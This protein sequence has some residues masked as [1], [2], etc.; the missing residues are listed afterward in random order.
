MAGSS[1]RAASMAVLACMLS[2][3]ATAQDA[4]ARQPTAFTLE[5]DNPRTPE[6][7]AVRFD[8][9]DLSIK[10]LPEDKAIDGVAV[11]D[12][13]VLQPIQRLAVELDTLFT[14][15]EIRLDG[16]IVPA[17]RWSNPE[18]RLTVE[19]PAGLAEGATPTLTI[20]YAGQPRVAPR[21][22]WNGGWVWA[23]APTGEPWIGSAVQLNGCDLVWPCID[24]SNAEPGQL[25]M[26][27]TTPGNVS[28]PGPGVFKG[29]T[30][31]T[32]GTKTWS[33]SIAHPNI[34]AGMINV[35][36]YEEI[37][38][39]YQSRFGNT[40]P[41]HYWHLRSDDPAKVQRLF[42]EF[43]P[44]LDFFESTIG[45]YP[46][47][48]SK[49]GVVETPYLG[50]EHQTINAYGNAY[51]IETRG[52][53]TLLQHEFSHEWFANQLTNRNAD[54]M[55][56]HE[57]LGSYM[58]PLYARYL[59]GERFMQS[60]LQ[61]QREG[62]VNAFPVVSQTNRTVNQV[63]GGSEGPGGDIYSKGSLIAHTLRMTI[64]DDDFYE[65][66][67]RLV[68]GRP[69]PRPGNFAPRTSSTREMNAIVNQVTGQDYDWFFDAYL[70]QAALPVLTSAREGDRL[71]LA[72]TTG[73]GSAFPM[74]VEIEVDGVTQTV[75][76]RDGR[77]AV[78][79]PAG[80]T[81]LVDPQNKLLRQLD[82]VDDWQAWNRAERERAAAE[83]LARSAG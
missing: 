22:P 21:A 35:G 12:F 9:A 58:Q 81:L 15:S 44:M 41:M 61:R 27:I 19:V 56:L 34:Y 2:V 49:M 37:T 68:Y 55:W 59:H 47:G 54:D 79:V 11:L 80:A 24:N 60:E 8:K 7:E 76:M 70:Y 23:T 39:P 20:A 48:D 42:A 30:E 67:R 31:N 5:T 6:Q 25:D 18:G 77:A 74:P 45:P 1:L 72:W 17:D 73:G 82:V 78:A 83:R 52:Y 53:D 66:I 16:E 38:A 32:D 40:I 62:L 13:T 4:P 43:A 57:G 28:A 33:W 14:I 26:H 46:F 69:D 3:P 63:Y 50:M 51:R 10:I 64:G 36:P 71:T 65:V 75:S 29:V